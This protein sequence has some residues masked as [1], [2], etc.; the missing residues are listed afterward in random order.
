MIRYLLALVLACFATP[1]AAQTIT[2]ARP[3]AASN[4]DGAGAL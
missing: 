4:G 3:F 1:L 2:V